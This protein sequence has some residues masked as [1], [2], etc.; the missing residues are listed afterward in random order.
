MD[1]FL[2]EESMRFRIFVFSVLVLFFCVCVGA[3]MYYGEELL[4][5]S[6]E[7]FNN[8]DVKYLRSAD[9]LLKTGKFTYENPEKS[10]VFIMPGIVFVLLPFVKLFGLEGAILPFQ[11]FSAFLQTITIYVFFHMATRQFGKLSAS[12]GLVAL[13]CY[14]PLIYI[15]TLLL[16]ETCF[17]F[18]FAW[19]LYFSV[20]ALE[21]KRKK[22]YI[23]AG[24]AW[25][26]ATLFRP[27]IFLYPLVIF[28]IWLLRKYSFREIVRNAMLVIIPFIFLLS[29]WWIRNAVTFGEFI[30]FTMSMGNPMLQGAFIDNKVYYGLIEKL[31]KGQL[32][33]SEDSL[34]NN[35]VEM[36]FA[37]LVSDY[38]WKEDFW[39][40]LKWNTLG[41]TWINFTDPY[42]RYEFLGLEYSQ[43]EKQHLLY[44][45][46]GVFGALM[47]VRR[48]RNLLLMFTVLYLTVA[49][50]TVLAYSRYMIPAV[51]IMILL[52][53]ECF[54]VIVK[55]CV[56]LVQ[57]LLQAENRV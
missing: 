45:L 8:D 4:L 28:M 1:F 14:I 54:A 32:Q 44:I 50:L 31:N 12:I 53:A 22:Y 34:W 37:K 41:K 5:G 7:E 55:K 27:M 42:C 49:P 29:P 46:M 33:Y 21:E 39:R 51:P 24:I 18:C 52:G 56:Y 15:S 43:I 38:Y 40:Y 13:S 19:L 36:E 11:I 16:T 2:K 6:L 30:P 57:F 10:T 20:M 23:M 9:T 47:C 17:L 26:M 48:K 3:S 35:Y 25:G